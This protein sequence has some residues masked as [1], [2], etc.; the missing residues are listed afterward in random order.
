[1]SSDKLEES[2]LMESG[3]GAHEQP[4]TEAEEPAVPSAEEQHESAPELGRLPEPQTILQSAPDLGRL[5]MEAWRTYKVLSKDW[6]SPQHREW[7]AKY[8]D[9]V[10]DACIQ[11]WARDEERREADRVQVALTELRALDGHTESP[12]F[13]SWMLKHGESGCKALLQFN[14]NQSGSTEDDVR[15]PQAV[16]GQVAIASLTRYPTMPEQQHLKSST[17]TSVSKFLSQWDK[18]KTDWKAVVVPVGCREARAPL[19]SISHNSWYIES[20]SIR[21]GFTRSNTFDCYHHSRLA[22]SSRDC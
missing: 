19:H 12:G 15:Q 11:R 16:V 2:L 5:T 8:P 17:E 3:T 20:N 22:S 4:E 18:F 7:A 9:V 6:R 10:I 14:T 1:M 13:R 21:A